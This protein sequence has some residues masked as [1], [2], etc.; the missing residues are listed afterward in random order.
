MEVYE[1]HDPRR[2][3]SSKQQ[4]VSTGAVGTGSVSLNAPLSTWQ[5]PAKQKWRDCHI[6]GLTRLPGAEIQMIILWSFV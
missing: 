3:E 4:S 6:D 1:H 2:F 5:T